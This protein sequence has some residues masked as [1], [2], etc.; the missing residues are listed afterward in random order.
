MGWLFEDIGRSSK[1]EKLKSIVYH[2]SLNVLLA[3]SDNGKVLV[4]DRSGIHLLHSADISPPKVGSHVPNDTTLV[5]LPGSAAIFAVSGQIV[6]LRHDTGGVLLLET[7]LQTPVEGKEDEVQIEL[8]TTE[9]LQLLSWLTQMDLSQKS[10]TNEW[11]N[12][13]VAVIK[14]QTSS[15]ATSLKLSY[16]AASWSV[17]SL[18]MTP[19]T[20]GITAAMKEAMENGQ[21]QAMSHLSS[22]WSRLVRLYTPANTTNGD[23]S[24]LST[25][26]AEPIKGLGQMALEANRLDS[27]FRWPHMNYRYALPEQM[28]QAGF[29][30][31]PTDPESDRALCFICNVCLVSWE[32][33]D[34]PWSEHERHAQN[35]PYVGGLGTPNVPLSVTMATGSAVQHGDRGEDIT[36]IATTSK[37]GIIATGTERGSVVV[38]NID[39]HL[40]REMSFEIDVSKTVQNGPDFDLSSTLTSLCVIGPCTPE[41]IRHGGVSPSLIAG[42]SVRRIHFMTSAVDF[43][44]FEPMDSPTVET[45]TNNEVKLAL[46]LNVYDLSRRVKPYELTKSNGGKTLGSD[47]LKNTKKKFFS[48]LSS[49][50]MSGTQSEKTSWYKADISDPLVETLFISD[51]LASKYGWPPSTKGKI[52]KVDYQEGSSGIKSDRYDD[53]Y[54]PLV[55]QKID[56]SA[57]I[58]EENGQNWIIHSI[59]PTLSGRTVLVVLKTKEE[60]D[61]DEGMLVLFNVYRS[62]NKMKLHEDPLAVTS[63]HPFPKQI[64]MVPC[65]FLCVEEFDFNDDLHRGFAACLASNGQLKLLDLELMEYVASTSQKEK[66]TSLTFCS[67]SDSICTTTEDGSLYFYRIIPSEFKSSFVK[68]SELEGEV[69]SSFATDRMGGVS[70]TKSPKSSRPSS[71]LANEEL[72]PLVLNQLRMLTQVSTTTPYFSATA[73]ATWTELVS[74]PKSARKL[75]A[76]LGFSEKQI[77]KSWRLEADVHIDFRFNL[78]SNLSEIPHIEIS[79]LSS[80]VEFGPSLFGNDVDSKIEYPLLTENGEML[81]SNPVK[82]QE[83]LESKEAILLAGPISLEECLDLTGRGGVVTLTSPELLNSKSRTFLIHIIALKYTECQRPTNLLGY[84]SSIDLSPTESKAQDDPAKLISKATLSPALK[85]CQLLQ[86]VSVTVRKFEIC[87]SIPYE[88]YQRS[89][90]FESKSFASSLIDVIAGDS[91]HFQNGNYSLQCLDILVWMGSILSSGKC[92]VSENKKLSVLEG[93]MKKSGKLAKNCCIYGNRSTAKKFSHLC[94]ILAQCAQGVNAD[95]A[96][97]KF[98]KNL[99]DSILA[100]LPELPASSFCGGWRWLFTLIHRLQKINPSKVMSSCTGLLDLCFPNMRN[101]VHPLHTLLQTRYGFYGLVFEP[102]L[103]ALPLVRPVY[104]LQAS[105]PSQYSYENISYTYPPMNPKIVSKAVAVQAPADQAQSVKRILS[106]IDPEKEARSLVQCESQLNGLMEVEPL[107]FSFFSASE[108]TTLEKN[109]SNRGM[110]TTTH[111]EWEYGL[112]NWSHLVSRSDFQQCILSIE[113]MHSGA[114]RYVTVDFGKLVLLTD[115]YVPACPHL[116][117]I[118]IETWCH[119]EETDPVRVALSSDIGSKSLLLT[120]IQPAILCRFLK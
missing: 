106:N 35:C 68:P 29:F 7:I 39:K 55:I 82:C 26:D 50:P 98:C 93:F 101:R 112:W 58:K 84:E 46:I 99:L 102:D 56:L 44:S 113:R 51:S 115:I 80:V 9:A 13:L 5:S 43:L 89:E 120:D 96:H 15:E 117:S 33:N 73:P 91:T 31:Q 119:R 88:R 107:G 62:E 60:T 114:R 22:L 4:Y 111:S 48:P 6:G 34:E 69:S 17:V 90:L 23:W 53:K 85:G 64:C 25:E 116:M 81:D 100:I 19:E 41:K 94:V 79:L 65:D 108:G 45:E 77:G 83:F 3:T 103:Y 87:K 49:S 97:L 63:L 105:P 28:S 8:Q 57:I 95:N 61:S 30:H 24:E 16:K 38:W 59:T 76:G 72:T 67:S 70:W 74:M 11:K 1:E 54:T 42:L 20:V 47:L 109:T 40:K 86:E 2:K 32:P 52:Q 118:T 18:K 71:L 104:S 21:I 37:E 14:E 78:A 66:L 36:C 27:F 12:K 75:P 110:R 10:K 92:A